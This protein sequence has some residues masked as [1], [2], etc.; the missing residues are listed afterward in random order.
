MM[1]K[2]D[3]STHTLDRHQRFHRHV[4]NLF[5]FLVSPDISQSLILHVHSSND[6]T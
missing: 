4:A 2:D 5:N 1:H 3:A 6:N